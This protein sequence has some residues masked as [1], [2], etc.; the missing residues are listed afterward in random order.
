MPCSMTG[1]AKNSFEF[2]DQLMTMEL[3]SVNHR[4]RDFQIHLPF[5]SLELERI[6]RSWLERAVSRGKVSLN[7]RGDLSTKSGN[8]RLIDSEV[9]H[10]INYSNT[11]R[12]RFSLSSPPGLAHLFS[13]PG[14]ISI[15]EDLSWV[16]DFQATAK[17]PFLDLVVEFNQCRSAEGQVLV[18]SLLGYSQ[19]LRK[20]LEKIESCRV[21]LLADH[22]EKLRAKI[23][24]L[25]DQEL[26]Q[27]QIGRAH[28]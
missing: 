6:F 20:S 8:V 4:Y 18:K 15:E 10:Y 16:Q 14:V 12:E 7:I 3:Q 9:E 21:G 23:A 22:V 13:L 24:L 5:P 17:K 19:E 2:R 28:V 11:I 1:Y 27:S 26:D 25:I